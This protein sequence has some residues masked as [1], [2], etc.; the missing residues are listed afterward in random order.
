MY[1]QNEG[2]CHEEE[3]KNV[4]GVIKEYSEYSS[5]AGLL[6][7]FMP[8]QTLAGK[9][10]WI[11]IIILM[12]ILGTYWSLSIYRDWDN[13]PVITTVASTALPVSNV[14]FPAG[15][16]IICLNRY[17][18]FLAKM[19]FNLFKFSSDVTKTAWVVILQISYDVQ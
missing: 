11:I 15:K 6:Y 2:S 16:V 5:I 8:D 13:Q 9:L 4:I 12:L 17:L 3:E 19:L 7:V 14:E 10:F 1:P 18:L